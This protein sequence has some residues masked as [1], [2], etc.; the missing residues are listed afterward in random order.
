MFKTNGGSYILSELDGTI[1]KRGVA[2]F[3]LLPYYSRDGTTIS[4]ERL[5][6]D[7]I[8]DQE[9]HMDDDTEGL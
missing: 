8:S 3:R 7:V 2:A 9:S 4:P 1:S 6:L 5:P